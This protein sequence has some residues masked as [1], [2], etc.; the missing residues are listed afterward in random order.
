MLLKRLE[1]QRSI[2]HFLVRSYSRTP[3]TEADFTVI[4]ETLQPRGSWKT[5]LLSPTRPANVIV[6]NQ[7]HFMWLTSYDES[8]I[9]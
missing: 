2:S 6:A 8:P 7:R 4:Q 5:D 1:N 9:I 3:L